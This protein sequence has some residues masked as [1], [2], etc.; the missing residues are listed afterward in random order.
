MKNKL[1][2]I[3]MVAS[4]IPPYCYGQNQNFWT[5]TTASGRVSQKPN[6]NQRFYELNFQGLKEA[7]LQVRSTGSN[8]RTSAVTITF[9]TS[10]GQIRK[11]SVSEASVLPE[12]L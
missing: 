5:E 1:L 2:L 3:I 10:D 4:L 12:E 7:V 8:A 11:F 6:Q 9:P